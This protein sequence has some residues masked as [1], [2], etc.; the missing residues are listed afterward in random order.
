MTAMPQHRILHVI[1]DLNVGGAEMVLYNLL[2]N[3]DRT[4]FDSRVVCLRAAGPVGKWISTLGVPVTALGMH[5][6]IPDPRMIIRL[7]RLMRAWKP[8]LVQTWMYHAD[9]A[10]GLAAASCRIP[11]VWGLHYTIS[12]LE[13]LKPVTRLVARVNAALSP[14]LP[15]RIVCCAHA[16]MQTHIQIGYACDRM[17]VITNGINLE[18]FK[19]DRAARREVRCELGLD[20]EAMLIGMC[21]RFDPQKDHRNFIRAAAE[22]SRSFPK[23][24]FVLWGDRV[25]DRN[26]DLATW[27]QETAVG[28]RVHL[29]GLR[30]DSPRLMASLDLASLSSAYGEAFPL[31]LGEAMACGVP[32]VATRIGDSANLI[33]ATGRVVPP[34]DPVAL[35]AA[36]VDLL[37]K[38]PLERLELGTAARQR[39]KAEFSIQKM[40]QRYEE[41]HREIISTQ[42]I[43]A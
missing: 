31:V 28:E 33:S 11:V 14:F 27:I 19:P 41:V 37:T 25:D 34:G 38:P 1:T 12:G 23:T 2:S 20:G 43:R 16:T 24:H 26:E 4:A 8:H 39:I 29:L 7:S 40:V 6:G 42:E 32:C 15:A 5:P 3:Q 35:A 13:L 18:K 21:A 10:G 17:T 30:S 36:W 9:L 22:F